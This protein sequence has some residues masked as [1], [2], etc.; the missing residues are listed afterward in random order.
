MSSGCGFDFAARD[1]TAA[2]TAWNASHCAR[3]FVRVDDVDDDD[4]GG[5]TATPDRSVRAVLVRVISLMYRSFDA[6]GALRSVE[7]PRRWGSAFSGDEM[8]RN[9]V[10]LSDKLRAVKGTEGNGRKQEEGR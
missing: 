5:V 8:N 6:F 1:M 7:R 9:N 10:N 4:S 3:T 2:R